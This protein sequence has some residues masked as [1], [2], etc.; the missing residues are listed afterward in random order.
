VPFI[1][2]GTINEPAQGF[3]VTKEYFAA[4]A[5]KPYLHNA[6]VYAHA[7]LFTPAHELLHLLG[8]VHPL[9]NMPWNLMEYRY[10]SWDNSPVADK[11][12]TQNQVNT[13]RKSE[14]LK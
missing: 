5:D 13:I 9:S 7:T 2:L 8:L 12:L 14:L 4:Q 1:I 3:A 11:R 6:F 10:S